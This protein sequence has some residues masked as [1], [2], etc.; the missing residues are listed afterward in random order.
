MLLGLGCG[1]ALGVA[2]VAWLHE[3]IDLSQWAA[4]VQFA[5]MRTLLV[6]QFATKDF[7]IISAI[8]MTLG[9]LGA[10][11]PAWRAVKLDPLE[12]LHGRT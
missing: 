4:G 8:V 3:G 1:L 7:G 5:G 11:Y 10:L 12:A 6:P 9:A 2:G